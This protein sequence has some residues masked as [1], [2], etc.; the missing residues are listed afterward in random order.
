MKKGNFKSNPKLVDEIIESLSEDQTLK[1]FFIEHDMPSQ[2]I[3]EAVNELLTFKREIVHCEGCPGLHAC[4]QDTVGIKPKL[5]YK[6][7]QIGLEYHPCHY[8]RAKEKQSVKK[9]RVDALFMPKMIYDA[10]LEDFYLD[11]QTRND[12]YKKIIGITNQYAKGEP[13]KGLYLHGRYQIGKTYSLAA[14]A[15]RFAELGYESIIAYYPDLVRELKSSIQTGNL[16]TRIN[17]LKTADILCLDDIGGESFSAWIRDEVLGPILQYRLL[18]DKPTFF[19][20]NLPLKELSKY[21]VS[22]NQQQEQIKG[23]RVIE[24]IKKLSEPFNM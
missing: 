13:I 22:S 6:N 3:E 24:R 7:G 20:S 5:T 17:Q 10:S 1:A 8:K 12:L 18:D 4:G 19:T 11:T 9:N 14:I 21:L 15:N 16:E 23:F 2:A